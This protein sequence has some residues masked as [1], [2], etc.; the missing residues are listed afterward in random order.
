[1]ICYVHMYVLCGKYVPTYTVIEDLKCITNS[2]NLC[3]Y[4]R[5]YLVM[6]IK[7]NTIE[8]LQK[9]TYAACVNVL[10]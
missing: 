1:M 9:G 8:L 6:D 4:V 5:K 10:N 3:I 7:M 2:L